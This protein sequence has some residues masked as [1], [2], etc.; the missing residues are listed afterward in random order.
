MQQQQVDVVGSE[1]AQTLLQA[2]AGV[3]R[4][5]AALLVEK[6]ARGSR[7]RANLIADHGLRAQNATNCPLCVRKVPSGPR[8][9]YA[10]FSGHRDF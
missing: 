9:P 2:T 5:I 10:K 3:N 6:T 4:V 8:R 1:P 7:V